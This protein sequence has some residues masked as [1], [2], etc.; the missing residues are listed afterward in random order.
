MRCIFC[1][2][3]SDSSKSVQ[4]IVPESLGNKELV[5]PPG[6]V[7]D[8]CN[9]YFGL[10]VE[11]PMLEMKYFC[12]LRFR[13]G[14]T[15][16]KNRNVPFETFLHASTGW[17]KTWVDDS[18][19][20]KINIIFEDEKV[21][22]LIQ[23]GSIKKMMFEVVDQPVQP[24][25]H[26]SR[27]LAKTAIEAFALKFDRDEDLLNEIIDMPQLDELREYARYGN[28]KQWLYHQRRIYSEETRFVN[29][30]NHPEPYE[31]M[32]E[33]DFLV[34]NPG[35]YYFVLVIMGI[36]YI[37]NCGASELNIYKQW[38]E[39]NNHQSPIR[40][41]TERIVTSSKSK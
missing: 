12:N 14:I 20:D 18:K 19:K 9:Q 4:H 10:K 34:I 41:G 8:N 2:Q 22:K 25:I 32:H 38:L 15:T 13:Q 23:N 3:S 11:K 1:I 30:V 26:I 5:L 29:P 37:I 6:I 21:S 31:V 16:K 27:F 39:E 7:C 36:E 24:N 28:G 35:I 33:M 17:T 40:R